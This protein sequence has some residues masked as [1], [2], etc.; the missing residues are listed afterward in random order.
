VLLSDLIPNAPNTKRCRDA[1]TSG[2]VP[3]GVQLQPRG[4]YNSVVGFEDIFLW[5]PDTQVTFSPRCFG[6]AIRAPAQGQDFKP[7][8]RSLFRDSI[9]GRE[10][11][12]PGQ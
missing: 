9:F 7:R 2:R 8:R 12:P 4:E 10:I 6:G 11:N 3:R 5:W 1:Y